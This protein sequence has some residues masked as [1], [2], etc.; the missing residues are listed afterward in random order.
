M[1]AECAQLRRRL[2]NS[3]SDGPTSSLATD[4]Q[5][6]NRPAGIEYNAPRLPQAQTTVETAGESDEDEPTEG[7]LLHDPDGTVRYL[8]ETSGATFLDYLKEFMTR[9]FIL[10]LGKDGLEDAERSGSF[11]A[12]IGQYQTLD[13]RSLFDPDVDVEW[14]PPK[15]EMDI[16]LPQFGQLVQG[17]NGSTLSGGIYYCWNFHGA[18]A[19]NNGW[20]KP[21]HLAV[22]NAAFALV[23]QATR[24]HTLP[25]TESHQGETFF[26]RAKLLV[27]N[28][29]DTRRYTIGD[30]SAMVLMGFYLIEMNRRDAA[31]MCINIAIQVSV[32]HGLHRGWADEQGKRVFWTLFILDRWLVCLMGRPPSI[33]DAAISLDLPMNTP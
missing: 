22:Y 21:Q 11:L 33:Q 24:I 17:G 30:I 25:R 13:S 20:Q 6:F 29:L 10:A 16:L 23:C 19:D 32:R 18:L 2:E 27:G 28:P 9:L 15:A 1:K 12:S 4:Q 26:K 7:R 5:L 31:C 8:G 3:A 14:L